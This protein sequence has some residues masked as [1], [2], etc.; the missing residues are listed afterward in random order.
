MQTQFLC[1]YWGEDLVST[2]KKK[3]IDLNFQ[4]L[5]LTNDQVTFSHLTNKSY[6]AVHNTVLQ[7]NE[8]SAAFFC[9]NQMHVQT[10]QRP[11]K[12]VNST[13]SSNGYRRIVFSSCR[14]GYVF[15]REGTC[16]V[17]H[18]APRRVSLQES[19]SAGR[20]FNL[21]FCIRP[22]RSWSGRSL[23]SPYQWHSCRPIS[24]RPFQELCKQHE[25]EKTIKTTD[26][27]FFPPQTTQC[28]NTAV[29]SYI[30]PVNHILDQM[31]E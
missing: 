23:S 24:H 19:K 26:F 21:K 7:T 27:F 28:R 14:S 30:V 20:S 22:V 18:V 10:M 16:L 1:R 29:V 8:E 13:L 31:L 15:K 6:L 12:L 17:F 2:T 4:R 3:K 11:C 25:Q 5:A 9:C